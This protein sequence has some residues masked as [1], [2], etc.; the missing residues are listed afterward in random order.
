[1]SAWLLAGF[2]ARMLST[3]MTLMLRPEVWRD[4]YSASAAG[5]YLPTGDP[6]LTPR[7]LLMMAGGLFIGG[8]WLVYL[9]ARSTFTADEKKFVAGLGRQSLR[10]SSASSIWP[11]VSG[12]RVF[13]RTPSKTDWRSHP[14]YHFASFAGYGWVALVVVAIATGGLRRFL[15]ESLRTG[16]AGPELLWRC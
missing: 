6:T 11:P 5:A 7:W 14:L 10:P 8:L 3:N 9:A 12:P 4:M 2:I 1:M 13:S 16:S 15:L